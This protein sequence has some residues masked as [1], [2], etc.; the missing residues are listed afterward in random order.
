MLGNKLA[1]TPRSG[2]GWLTLISRV[3]GHQV[4]LGRFHLSDL[5]CRT[6][7]IAVP[8]VSDK[9]WKMHLGRSLSKLWQG[10][11]K[12]TGRTWS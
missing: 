4:V 6:S 1:I 2:S 8:Q 5:R 3:S 12:S 11:A 9:G 7:A 10:K